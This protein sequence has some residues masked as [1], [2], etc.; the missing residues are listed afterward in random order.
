MKNRKKIILLKINFKQ[1]SI[2]IIFIPSLS[3]FIFQNNAYAYLDPGSFSL[4]LQGIIAGLASVIGV[5]A[6][7][8]IK[9]KTF[10]KRFMKWK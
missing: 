6:M 9:I 5:V 4:V 3:F 2:L 8:W 10:I 1:L 7:Y